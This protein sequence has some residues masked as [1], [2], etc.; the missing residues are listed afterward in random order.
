MKTA[1]RSCC[2]A[3]RVAVALVLVAVIAYRAGVGEL[4]ASSGF[5]PLP[6]ML[7]VVLAPVAVSL[8]AVSHA[9]LLNHPRKVLGRW[10]ALRLTLVGSGLALLVPGGFSDM[11][12]AHW[13][14]RTHGNAEAMV[15]SS[16][17]DKLTSLLALSGVAVIG[18]LVAGNGAYLGL[19]AAAAV[20]SAFPFVAPGAVPWMLLLRILAPGAV[21]DEK[22][23]RA[24]GRPPRFLM[25]G[26][27]G[28]SVVGW[29][30]TYVIIWACCRGVGADVTFATV[31]LVGP[32]STLTRLIPVSVAGIGVADATLA[33]LLVLSGVPDALA[34][35]ATL[36]VLLLTVLAPGAAGMM[37]M[38]AGGKRSVSSS[39]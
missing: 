16:V 38:A 10:D 15:I 12:K 39:G 8:R 14:W 2:R 36:V 7:A 11:A 37:V 35:R 22:L 3:A 25:A 13:G 33:G 31:L 1:L 24:F 5:E 30:A 20:V 32:V 28:V 6:L 4:G 34:A 27:V 26:V 21:V 23:V 9:L 19:A 18:A 17:V 29:F